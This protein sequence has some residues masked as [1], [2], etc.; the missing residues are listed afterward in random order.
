MKSNINRSETLPPACKEL[1]V[2][3]LRH[4]KYL[5][6]RTKATASIS[7][8]AAAR[9]SHSPRVGAALDGRLAG[10][11][12]G[13]QDC[14]NFKHPFEQLR[15]LRECR[16]AF[17]DQD[18]WRH[19]GEL[20]CPTAAGYASGQARREHCYGLSPT[21]VTLSERY[22]ILLR[23]IGRFYF[24]VPFATAAAVRKRILKSK[25]RFQFSMYFKS[26]SMLVLND[27]S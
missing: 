10:V 2:G 22:S 19:I 4:R 15:L 1:Q 17:S 23:T 16:P 14:S 3:K 6:P 8:L 9:G 26:H 5:P 27:G 12:Y 18:S 13:A 24:P 21:P 25:P 11:N 7:T 20:H